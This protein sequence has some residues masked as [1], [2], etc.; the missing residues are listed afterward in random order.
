MDPKLREVATVACV[1]LLVAAAPYGGAIGQ[2]TS[3]STVEQ[4]V[5]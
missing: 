5:T 2:E 1:V 3:I 4:P